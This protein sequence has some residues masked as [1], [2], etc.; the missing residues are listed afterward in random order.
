[1]VNP[2]LDSKTLTV[3]YIYDNIYDDYIAITCTDLEPELDMPVD[4][5]IWYDD[6]VTKE[7]RE[8]EKLS[9]Y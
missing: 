3:W 7:K 4:L 2:Y 9:D 6:I 5:V 1:M 8:R